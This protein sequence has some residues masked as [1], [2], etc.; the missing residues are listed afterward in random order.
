MLSHIYPTAVAEQWITQYKGFVALNQDDELDWNTAT[1]H[2]R[3]RPST[4]P[5]SRVSPNCTQRQ[6]APLAANGGT[7]FHP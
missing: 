1:R 7:L 6:G 3:M 4:G 5:P 2:L